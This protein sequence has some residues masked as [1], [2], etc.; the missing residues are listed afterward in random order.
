[1]IDARGAGAGDL[2]AHLDEAVGDVGDLGLARGVLDHGR[3]VGQR[4]RHQRGVGGADR[5]LREHDLAALAGRS[6]RAA[7]T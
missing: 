6:W 7:I 3:A 4:R 5:D 1:M 2:G